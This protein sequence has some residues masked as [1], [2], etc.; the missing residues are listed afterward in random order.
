MAAQAGK[1]LLLKC[2]ADGTGSFVTMAGLRARRIA[3][4]QASVDVTDADSAGRWRELLAG[5]GTR[6]ASVSGGGIFRD[7]AA[8]ETVRGLFFDGLMRNWQVVI[9]DFGT[10]TGPFQIAS[11]DYAGTHDGE[12][13]YEIAL[14]SAGALGFSGA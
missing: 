14:E 3:L 4:N 7:A 2:D 5:G 9:P 8:D 11:L 13:T 10:I 12:V 1:D 6:S